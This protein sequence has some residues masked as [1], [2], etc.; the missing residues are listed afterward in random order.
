LPPSPIGFNGIFCNRNVF[1]SSSAQVYTS[2]KSKAHEFRKWPTVQRCYILACMPLEDALL[3]DESVNNLRAIQIAVVIS[4][5]YLQYIIRQSVQAVT[6]HSDVGCA[7]FKLK[8]IV[9]Q[10][11]SILQHPFSIGFQ[12]I[13]MLPMQ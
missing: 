10:A 1:D 3:S 9:S 6:K 11:L 5:P 8:V 4:V 7:T 12:Y 2:Y 13:L